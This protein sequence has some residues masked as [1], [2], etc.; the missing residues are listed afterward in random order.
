LCYENLCYKDAFRGLEAAKFW[1]TLCDYY[2]KYRGLLRISESIVPWSVPLLEF[3]ERHNYIATC[4]SYEG[5]I[6]R[7][8]GYAVESD[9]IETFCNDRDNHVFYPH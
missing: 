3:L 2:V 8:E 9:N 4:D 7:V 6:L 1:Q 5:V